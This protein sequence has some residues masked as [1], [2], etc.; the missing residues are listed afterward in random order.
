MPSSWGE[1]WLPEGVRKQ[2]LAPRRNAAAHR[3]LLCCARRIE[4]RRDGD[5]GS[6]LA[7]SG[8]DGDASLPSLL[9]VKGDEPANRA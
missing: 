7:K 5:G 8:G 3:M 1:L 6:A 4:A 9:A 2:L